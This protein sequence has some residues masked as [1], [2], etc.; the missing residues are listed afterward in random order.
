[1][2]KN[3]SWKTSGLDVNG[4]KFFIKLMTTRATF[5]ILLLCKFYFWYILLLIA[6]DDLP[7]LV[8]IAAA[9]IISSYGLETYKF[10]VSQAMPR[11]P[12]TGNQMSTSQCWPRRLWRFSCELYHNPLSMAWVFSGS[13][14]VSITLKNW[15]EPFK[16]IYWN[17]IDNGNQLE[18][19]QTSPSDSIQANFK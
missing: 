3:C 15:I 5:G 14:W 6:V 2:K 18:S 13:I 16:I 10:C 9:K 7:A 4:K 8:I 11:C 19:T 1:M 12:L 17:R